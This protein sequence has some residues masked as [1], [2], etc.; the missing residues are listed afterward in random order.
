MTMLEKDIAVIAHEE[1][2]NAITRIQQVP[3]G[4][5]RTSWNS[6]PY[7]EGSIPA[8]IHIY[9]QLHQALHHPSDS[10]L[11]AFLKSE[12]TKLFPLKADEV[13]ECRAHLGECMECSLGKKKNKTQPLTYRWSTTN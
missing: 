3:P 6:R 9:H 4:Y 8:K 2:V 13:D 5:K 1:H 12:W 11:K 10:S 7:Q